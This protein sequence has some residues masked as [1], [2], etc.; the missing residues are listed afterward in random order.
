MNEEATAGG[1]GRYLQAIRLEKAITLQKVSEETRIGLGI[2]KSIEQ[3]Q[4]EELPAE[5]FLKGFLR[6][7]S[8]FV[9]A[10]EGEVIRRYDSQMEV[11]R[12]ITDF[13]KMP[14]VV[15]TGA[16]WKFLLALAILLLVIAVSIF[17]VSLWHA[18]HRS[19]ADLQGAAQ[20]ALSLTGVFPPW[21]TPEPFELFSSCKAADAPQASPAKSAV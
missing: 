12:R 18:R 9:G 15:D 20:A 11:T 19:T 3:E 4:L 6:S 2:L 21:T 17:G 7:Y 14:G 16:V 5:V 10:D 1:F 13:E 8:K